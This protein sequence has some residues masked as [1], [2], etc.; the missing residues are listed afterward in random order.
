MQYTLNRHEQHVVIE[1]HESTLDGPTA[2][3]LRD[4][5]FGLGDEGCGSVILDITETHQLEPEGIRPLL[6]AHRFCQEQ[7]GLL[8]VCGAGKAVRSTLSL[9]LPGEPLHL[10]QNQIDAT[11]TV[12]MH[13][14]EIQLLAETSE[15][16]DVA[17]SNASGAD[18]PL[19][20]KALVEALMSELESNGE[21]RAAFEDDDLGDE[22][23]VGADLD[24]DDDLSLD[25]LE[26]DYD[27]EDLDDL[28][29]EE[30]DDDFGDD[31]A[32]LEDDLASLDEDEDF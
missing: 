19:V 11:E 5:V 24:D 18:A 23:V 7:D 32:D 26:D 20:D 13:A 9:M 1:L 27:E 2:A 25:D 3:S 21:L 22:D 14:I 4:L 16:A 30:F 17:M 12:M 8:V 31:D 28:D 10:A 29:A 15:S 6:T